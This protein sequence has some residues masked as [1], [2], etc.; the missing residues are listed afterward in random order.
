MTPEILAFVQMFYTD[1]LTREINRS[2]DLLDDFQ[3]NNI[4]SP[5]ID[6]MMQHQLVTNEQLMDEF[7]A[8]LN[9]HLD[10]VL[11]E[12]TVIL[13]D[14]A[15]ITEKNEVLSA[16]LLVQNL[17]D[18]TGV[19]A[20]LESL[21]PDEEQLADIISDL[22]S[23]DKI[24]VIRIVEDFNPSILQH[25]L[26]YIEDKQQDIS[27]EPCPDIL[28]AYKLFNECFGNNHIAYELV[29]NGLLLNQT[30]ELYLS[31]VKEDISNP[32]LS[33]K[34]KALDI[35]SI[36]IVSEDGNK[37]PTAI[38][39]QYSQSLF[40]DLNQIKAVESELTNYIAIYNQ[41]KGIENEKSR[42]S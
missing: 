17:E 11:S 1:E 27:T 14:E 19:I 30:F 39:R 24:D 18:Y 5:Y 35:Y 21:A 32:E 40:Q 37:E 28:K 31:Y 15:T 20:A 12:H 16:L 8:Q 34:Q 10:Y 29:E 3:L 25:L 7:I 41:R 6:I 23:L 13:I 42:L 33:A 9:R 22:S 2:F 38:Y 4:D 26:K 36:L